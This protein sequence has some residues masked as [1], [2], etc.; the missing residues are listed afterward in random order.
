MKKIRY[1]ET[2]IIKVL[3]EVE[4]GRIIKGVCRENGISEYRKQRTT[5]CSSNCFQNSICARIW[6]AVAFVFPAMGSV[7]M[8][9]TLVV[10]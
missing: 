4:G 1:A 3:S 7:S 10:K 8:K 5:T 9:T 6:Y 2:Q